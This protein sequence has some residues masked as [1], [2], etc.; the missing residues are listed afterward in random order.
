MPT[1]SAISSSAKPL[2]TNHGLAS[3]RLRTRRVLCRFRP[4]EDGGGL[5]EEAAEDYAMYLQSCDEVG[6]ETLYMS[7]PG[8]YDYDEDIYE[9]P[10]YEIIEVDD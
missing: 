7:N 9:P 2:V 10:D 3:D 6:A 8:D 1:S 4:V 5:T